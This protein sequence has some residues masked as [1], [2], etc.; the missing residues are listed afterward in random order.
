MPDDSSTEDFAVFTAGL[1]T[2]TRRKRQDSS[3][4]VPLVG[5]SGHIHDDGN[6]ESVLLA[7]GTNILRGSTSVPDWKNGRGVGDG[8]DCVANGDCSFLS[9]GAERG[10]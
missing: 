3:T 1:S 7:E 9:G 8:W 5:G 10:W 4:E 6:G 2:F